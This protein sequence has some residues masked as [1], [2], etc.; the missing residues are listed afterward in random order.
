MRLQPYR[1]KI[2]PKVLNLLNEAEAGSHE[3]IPH[4]EESL[5]AELNG[6]S[7]VLLATDDQDRIVGFA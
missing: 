7:S 3:F 1:K 6:A 2:L 5:Q 4:G